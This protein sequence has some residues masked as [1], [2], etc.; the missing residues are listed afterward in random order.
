MEQA[1]DEQ[2]Q[3]ASDNPLILS[4]RVIGTPVYN[5]EGERLGHVDDLSI[6]KMSGLTRYA[7][8][9][10]GGFLGL[11]ERFH[12]VPWSLLDYD[13][14]QDGFVVPLDKSALE[15]AP[16]YDAAEIRNLGGPEHRTYGNTIFDYY[17]PYGTDPY[18]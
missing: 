3:N 1:T 6:E 4:S 12:P 5:R 10:F 8:I 14:K 15:G 11:G 9:S 16:H 18:W 7:V 2:V 13:V 17:R